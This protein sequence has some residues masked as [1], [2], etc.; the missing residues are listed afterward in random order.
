MA[1]FSIGDIIASIL[2][3]ISSIVAGYFA[4]RSKRIEK[5][6]EKESKLREAQYQLELKQTEIAYNSREKEREQQISFYNKIMEDYNSV[7]ALANK[8]QDMVEELSKEVND[9][10]EKLKFYEENSVGREAREIIVKIMDS[11]NMPAWIHE[12]D[13]HQWY[14]ND[15][16]CEIFKINRKNFW[17]SVNIFAFN[18]QGALD[19][20]KEDLEVYKSGSSLEFIISKIVKTNINQSSTVNCKIVKAPFSVGGR[21]YI[22]GRVLEIIRD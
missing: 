12:I 9:L 21:A 15:E 1:G 5:E 6:A 17:S 3:L 18:E 22:F 4:V 14:L 16:Y 20:L 10:R 8:L 11:F 2:A 13:T 19:T 7:R